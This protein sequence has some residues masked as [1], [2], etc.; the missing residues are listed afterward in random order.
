VKVSIINP[1]TGK[2]ISRSDQKR[3]GKSELTLHFLSAVLVLMFFE[4][5]LNVRFRF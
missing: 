4:A 2:Q 1:V 5:V 3:F